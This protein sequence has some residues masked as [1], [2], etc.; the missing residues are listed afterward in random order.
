MDNELAA[1][2]K[3]SLSGQTAPAERSEKQLP[4]GRP[5]RHENLDELLLLQLGCMC[6]LTCAMRR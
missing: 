5:I 6:L 1:I 2:K 3:R 4:E